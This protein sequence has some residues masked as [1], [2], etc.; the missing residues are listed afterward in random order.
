MHSTKAPTRKKLTRVHSLQGCWLLLLLAFFIHEA[1]C[2]R[3]SQSHLQERLRH[4]VGTKEIPRFVL[5]GEAET[6]PWKQ[7]QVFYR[8]RR[9]QPAWIRD[10]W[11]GG[12]TT[13]SQT[14]TLLKCLR[15]ASQEGLD[16]SEYAADELEL[17]VGKIQRSMPADE[18]AWLDARLTYSFF[19]FAA[20]LYR[21]RLNPKR[22]SP[23]WQV[24]SRK[25]E[26]AP[27]LEEALGQMNVCGALAKLSPALPEYAAL[28]KALGVYRRIAEEGGW[29]LVPSIKTLKTGDRGNA[30]NLLRN[31]LEKQGDF[32]S[33]GPDTGRCLMKALLP[34]CGP[35]KPATGCL[36]ME[37]LIQ[38]C[39]RP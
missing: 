38:K 17:Q 10:S 12:Q 19:E 35:L 39:S 36:W 1:G 29:P 11:L 13:H 3:S 20:H 8:Q 5:R 37:W 16:P 14:K 21:G 15:D 24:A 25:R 27:V 2:G 6:A 28:R 26:F 23:N 33:H 7:T 31:S 18:L 9:F 4:I 34:Q 22:I 32:A 30:V